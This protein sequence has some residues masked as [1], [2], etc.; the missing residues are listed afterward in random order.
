MGVT[1]ML[2]SQ[3]QVVHFTYLDP[4]HCQPVMQYL[5]AL[6]K[7]LG[8]WKNQRLTELNPALTA[9]HFK[10]HEAHCI[11]MVYVKPLIAAL[12]T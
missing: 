7:I 1:Q 2:L 10:K 3:T 8:S 4:W 11:G 6:P 5:S 9:N 12:E